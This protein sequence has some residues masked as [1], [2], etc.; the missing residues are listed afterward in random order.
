VQ[1]AGI[2]LV[3][4]G[5]LVGLFTEVYAPSDSRTIAF[6]LWTLA[7]EDPGSLHRAVLLGGLAWGL[8]LA[9]H[10]S[11]ALLLPGVA[12]AVYPKRIPIHRIAPGVLLALAIILASWAYLPL[13]FAANPAYNL[14]GTYAADGAFQAVDLTARRSG[15]DLSGQ[16][17][18]SLSSA[19]AGCLRCPGAGYATLFATNFWLR[20]GDRYVWAGRPR[21]VHRPL[22]GLAGAF[23]PYVYFYTTYGREIGI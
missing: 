19:Q 13:R 10:P 11:S 21:Q 9:I 1:R 23:V 14:A 6:G 7:G 16:Q 17:F 3:L 18:D 5:W 15:L 20:T 12:V 2:R 22:V 8:A 4:P